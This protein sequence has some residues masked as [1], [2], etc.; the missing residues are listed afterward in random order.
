MQD[1]AQEAIH[2]GLSFVAYRMLHVAA[3]LLL[4]ACCLSLVALAGCAGFG[5]FTGKEE[6]GFGRLK[7]TALQEVQTPQQALLLGE[8]L[9]YSVRWMGIE[10]GT[11]QIEVKEAT[12]WQGHPVYRVTATAH[13]NR[14]LS[15]IYRVE[16]EI[17]SY[18][19]A[20][21]FF[22]W[23]FV[24]RQQEG[25]YRA[26]E[27]MVYDHEKG[28]ATYRSFLN[29][30]TKQMEIPR[31]IQDSLSVLYF[32]RLQSLEIGKSVFIPVNADEKNW[33]LEIRVLKLGLLEGLPGGRRTAILTEPLAKFHGVFVRKG[34]VWI[35]FDA[36]THRAPLL[37]RARLP[38]G[39]V[40]VVLVRE[41]YGD[42]K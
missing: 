10:V 12:E 17:D 15:M 33:N 4:A 40:E 21:E 27:E 32:F 34:R 19:D 29:Q 3:F 25:H 5:K 7:E 13:S 38:F 20:K 14:L 37:M 42:S 35:W 9:T 24:K 26:H 8:K 18:I 23:R 31:G 16:D 39:L 36:G 28:I 30:S 6:L 11:A 41:S 1:K 2:L 22:P